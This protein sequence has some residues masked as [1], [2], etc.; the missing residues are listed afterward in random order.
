MN[1]KTLKIL[2]T[3]SYIAL[4]FANIF[5]NVFKLGGN[6]TGGVSAKYTTLITPAP[7]T[8]S[9]WA[10]IYSLILLFVLYQWGVFDK[11]N[12]SDTVRKN[13]GLWFCVSCVLNIL[14]LILWHFQKIGLSTLVIAALLISLIIIRNILDKT[15]TE[16]PQILTVNI[17]FSLYFGWLIAATITNIAVFLK[18]VNWNGFSL[19]DTFWAIIVLIVGTV[20]G[21]LLILKKKNFIGALAV[22]WAY[23]GILARHIG[24]T[25]FNG[26]YVSVIITLAICI[27]VLLLEIAVV[28]YFDNKKSA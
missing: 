17:G 12:H 6:T 24:R 19:S 27:A 22:I 23:V 15:P 21:S 28:R 7:F 3:F 18:S 9:I 10:V 20:I 16:K 2:N 26:A 4:I 13:I 5:V 14:W 11:T 1:G 8:F 25:G